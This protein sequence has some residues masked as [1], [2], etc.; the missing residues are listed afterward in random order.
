MGTEEKVDDAVII[1]EPSTEEA[2]KVENV[3][4]AEDV[5][6][7][8]EELGDNVVTFGDDKAPE[9]NDDA[10]APEWVKDLRRV[11]RA[12]ARE[13]T[14]LKKAKA[15]DKP[16]SLSAKPTL[17]G[18]GYDEEKHGKLLDVWYD[19]KRTHDDAETAKETEAET[20]RVAW[21]S[22]LEEYNDAK[23]SFTQDTIDD[24]EA[25][26][27][28]M[29]TDTQQG[30]LVEALGKGAAALLVGLA[31]NDTRFKA[32]ASIKNPIRFAAEAARLESIMKTTTRRPKTI[33][34]KRVV[35]SG[36]SQMG[37]KTLEKL[38]AEAEKS[39][40]RSK[41]VAHKRALKKAS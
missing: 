30:V 38:E 17:E 24:A 2:D 10:P 16:S 22:R 5:T 4:E 39:G 14:E 36:A 9:V 6:E 40:D 19:E 41:I 18:S 27:R 15:D 35:G 34:E 28:E 11:N 8:D 1:E 31:A 29:L 20:Q 7:T 32:L 26:A 3:D 33:P 12:Q 25:I 23:S 13:L 21:Q 37:D